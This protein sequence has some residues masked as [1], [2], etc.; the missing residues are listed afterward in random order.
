MIRSATASGCETMITC[1][2]S[3]SVIFAPART[4]CERTRSVPMALSPDATT[5]QEGRCFHAAPT[6]GDLTEPSSVPDE[7]PPTVTALLDP[8]DDP[9]FTLSLRPPPTR[10]PTSDASL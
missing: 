10:L 3:S 1:D 2:P 5:A 6:V 8:A 4:A 7:Q 9:A